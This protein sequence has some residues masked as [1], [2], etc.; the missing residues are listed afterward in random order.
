MVRR[1]HRTRTKS[2]WLVVLVVVVV[3]VRYWSTEK[4]RPAPEVLPE[5]IYQVERVVD[6]DT[7]E[8]ANGARVRLIGVDTPETVRPN[9]PV[10]PF[11]PEATAFTKHFVRGGEVE[12][13]L[14]K[15]RLDRYGR[16]LVYVW[17]DNQMLNEELVRAGLARAK[18][19]FYYYDA[20]KRR[21]RAA[22]QEARDA[23]RGIWS[24]P[25]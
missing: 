3:L 5:G 6:G 23:N 18:T 14:D 15:E 7:L 17:V 4:R 24:E 11:G 22:E 12:L 10:E 25:K 20:M 16:F 8:L 13:R 9:H 19:S 21:F 1:F 2:V